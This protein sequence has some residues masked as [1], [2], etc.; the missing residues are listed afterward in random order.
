MTIQD[1]IEQQREEIQM[2]AWQQISHLLS[3]M[4]LNYIMNGVRQGRDLMD[5][6]LELDVFTKY[7]VDMLKVIEILRRKYPEEILF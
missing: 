7:Q 1:W 3:D 4:E 5:L 6:H 2:A